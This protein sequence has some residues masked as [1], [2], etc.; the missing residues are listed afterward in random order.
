MRN[1]PIPTSPFENLIDDV[2]QSQNVVLELPYH[3]EH[4]TTTAEEPRKERLEM[5]DLMFDPDRYLQDCDIDACAEEGE[6]DMVYLQAVQMVPHW[7]L[8]MQKQQQGNAR[9]INKRDAPST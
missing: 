5:E 1:V 3:P 6:G 4:I 9:D 7:V 8:A 2:I